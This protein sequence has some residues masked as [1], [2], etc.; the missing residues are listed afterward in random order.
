MTRLD[1]LYGPLY[2][3]LLHGHAP[4]T[5]RFTQDVIDMALNGIQPAADRGAV[6]VDGPQRPYLKKGDQ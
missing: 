6:A 3:R 1:A 5:D 4:L 2:H